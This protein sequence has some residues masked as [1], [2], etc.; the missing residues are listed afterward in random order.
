MAKS[1]FR[2]FIDQAGTLP[3][4]VVLGHIVWHTV[5]DG[6]YE[7]SVIEQTFAQL[8]LDPQFIPQPTSAF[9]AFEKACTNALKV[10]KPYIIGTAKYDR[11]G[12][13][14]HLTGQIMAIREVFKNDEVVTRR[15]IREIRD[16][17]SKVL[18][19]EEIGELKLWREQRPGH[20]KL[21][22]GTEQPPRPTVFVDKLIGGEHGEE[23]PHVDSV[24][25]QFQS[26]Y[27][28]LYRYIDGDKMRAVVREYLKYLNSVMMKS[29]VYFVHKSR[30]E[31]LFRLQTFVRTMGGGCNLELIPIPELARLRESVI[32]AFQDEAVK[33]LDEVVSAISK[34]RGSR[35]T[36]TSTA[37]A[38]LTEQYQTTMRKS[39]EYTRV[40]RITQDRTAGA[41]EIALA[42]LDALRSDMVKQMEA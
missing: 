6:A 8:D 20:G 16:S 1:E 11:D 9:N 4:D 32:E 19:H 22:R 18:R 26:E 24:I 3:D 7:L 27:D 29:G 34:V 13:P 5:N 12:T 17:K 42:A 38:K 10:G 23:R 35:T 25:K 14:L 21:R 37:F 30:E 40:L 41:A 28:R 39:T 33:E 2:K 36:I 15:I 31:E